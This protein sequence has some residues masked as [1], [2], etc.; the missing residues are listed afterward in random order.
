MAD[1]ATVH[2]TEQTFDE[3]LSQHS[4]L[5]MVDF[6]AEWCGPCR[7]LSPVSRPRGRGEPCAGVRRAAGRSR[8]PALRLL[9]APPRALRVPA[10]VGGGRGGLGA[11][12]VP[13]RRPAYGPHGE[14]RA[15]HAQ[16]RFPP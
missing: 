7:A 16:A 10:R 1:T 14:E 6:W 2:L 5:M 8:H 9:E 13:Q 3:A 11:L 4:G 12:L 15:P